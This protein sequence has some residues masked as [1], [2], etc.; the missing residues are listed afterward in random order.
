MFDCIAF[1]FDSEDIKKA[2]D[3]SRS[4]YSYLKDIYNYE[5][6]FN[7]S[8]KKGFHIY[9]DFKPAELKNFKRSVRR[10]YSTIRQILQLDT[11][12]FSIVGD[13]RRL[14]RLPYTLHVSG[15]RYCIPIDYY[16]GLDKILKQAAKPDGLIS[17]TFN[18]S[19]SIRNIL[20]DY[21]KEEAKPKPSEPRRELKLGSN[22]DRLRL[23]IDMILK[24]APT[25]EDHR[26][27]ILHFM[28]VPRLMLIG[29]T[30]DEVRQ[31]CRTYIE[32]TWGGKTYDEYSR[33]VEDSIART[34]DGKWM[35]WKL[36]T[37][38][39]HFPDAAK[40]FRSK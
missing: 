26:H 20:M 19:I 24:Y 18:H 15:R 12:D 11:L 27:R 36:E 7:F 3:E 8:G 29:R 37:F 23:E 10:F 2:Y 9:I 13:R 1:D 31:D 14:M 4:L 34:R 25:T 5:P 32:T 22:K 35:P 38:I 16:W 6:R 17:Q 33:Y 40:W 28:L 21:D 39:E 30:D